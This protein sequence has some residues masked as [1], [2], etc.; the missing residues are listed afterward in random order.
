MSGFLP[1]GGRKRHEGMVTGIASSK[2]SQ[3]REEW[4][5][6]FPSLPFHLED[7]DAR[8]GGGGIVRAPKGRREET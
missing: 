2:R 8:G 1:G 6:S 5:A 4:W 7:R 3:G